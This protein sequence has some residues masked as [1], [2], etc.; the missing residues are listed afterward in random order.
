MSTNTCQRA[1]VKLLYSV[2]L[3]YCNSPHAQL[4]IAINTNQLVLFRKG[5]VQNYLGKG[6][7]KAATAEQ[8]IQVY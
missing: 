3:S 8:M 1:Q 4:K 6:H 5:H 2:L 7:T